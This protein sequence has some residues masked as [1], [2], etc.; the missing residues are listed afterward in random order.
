[1]RNWL[2]YICP[3]PLCWWV[4]HKMEKRRLFFCSAAWAWDG[5]Q[6][7]VERTGVRWM[8]CRGTEKSEEELLP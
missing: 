5:V 2:W 3:A 8:L 1:M 7:Y 6:V 4:Y